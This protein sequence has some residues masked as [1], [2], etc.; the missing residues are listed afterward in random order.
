MFS[1]KISL[2]GLEKLSNFKDGAM[3]IAQE[4]AAAQFL[5]DVNTG[6]TKSGIK[7]PIDTGYLRGSS[8]A[9]VNGKLVGTGPAPNTDISRTSDIKKGMVF[10]YNADYAARLHENLDWQPGPKSQNDGQTGPRW[11]RRALIEDGE[12]I[13]KNIASFLKKEFK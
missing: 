5:A 1:L 10:V 6:N 12:S 7:P 9:F 2:P 3:Q 4:K 11:L 13:T 8:S